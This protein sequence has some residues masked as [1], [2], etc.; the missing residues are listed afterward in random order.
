MRRESLGMNA[1]IGIGYR[2]LSKGEHAY[3]GVNAF[4][5]HVFKGGYKRVSGGDNRI[6]G[7]VLMNFMLICTEIWGLMIENI[8][9]TPWGSNVLDDPADCIHMVRILIKVFLIMVWFSYEN[10]WMLSERLLLVDLM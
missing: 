5:N 1:N 10:H 4:Y 8:Y 9:R 6:C 3:V 7:E 2:R